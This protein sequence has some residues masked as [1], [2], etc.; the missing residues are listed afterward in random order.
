LEH[1]ESSVATL[2][3][4]LVGGAATTGDARHR[5][6]EGMH[7][8]N[9][10]PTRQPNLAKVQ[11]N[12]QGFGTS[13]TSSSTL[14]QQV[15]LPSAAPTLLHDHSPSQNS[16]MTHTRFAFPPDQSPDDPSFNGQGPY[17]ASPG[18]AILH[19]QSSLGAYGSTD[20]NQLPSGREE[21]HG[22]SKGKGQKA[23]ERLAV[24]TEGV[25]EPP[26]KALVYQVRAMR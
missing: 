1:L 11:L 21:W 17:T 22:K 2:L 26:F 5:L 8:L 14:A 18:S 15:H 13:A 25:F 3:A 23:E 10:M 20:S 7:G 9:T 19:R 6:P 12:S 4:G 24:A 16:S